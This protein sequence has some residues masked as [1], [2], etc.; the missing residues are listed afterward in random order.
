[1]S[2]DIT[3]FTILT[4]LAI[5]TIFFYWCLPFNS[6]SECFLRVC[7]STNETRVFVLQQ[8][9]IISL[10]RPTLTNN[11][12]AQRKINQTLFILRV[13]LQAKLRASNNSK[14]KTQDNNSKSS[15]KLNPTFKGQMSEVK[16]PVYVPVYVQS[17]KEFEDL[18]GKGNKS[19]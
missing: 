5:I 8:N 3:S 12:I 9:L 17:P 6:V 18:F 14:F 2:Q 15:P 13:L 7:S 4:S 1:M 10:W 11:Q 19:S 16:H